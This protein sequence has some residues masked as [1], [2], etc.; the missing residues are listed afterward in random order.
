VSSLTVAL[1]RVAILLPWDLAR[2]GSYL[3][4]TSV[5]GANIAVWIERVDYFQNIM[6]HVPI[7]PPVD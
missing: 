2:L 3:A 1:A 6:A 7:T 5:L 4:A